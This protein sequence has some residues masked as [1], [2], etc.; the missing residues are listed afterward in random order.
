MA[1]QV[2]AARVIRGL[3]NGWPLVGIASLALAAMTGAVLLVEGTGEA[4]VRL[5]IRATARSSLLI[6]AFA[7]S[8]SSL[9]RLWRSDATKWLLRNRRQ[10]GLSFAVSHFIHLAAIVALARGWPDSFWADGP[11]AIL[12][13]G[14]VGYVFV[15]AM[16]ATSF[17]RSAAWLGRRRW[18]RLHLTGSWVLWSIFAF[19]Y[20]ARVATGQLGFLPLALLVLAVPGLRLAARRRTAGGG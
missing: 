14:G 10:I 13:G 4:G 19:S 16:T 7:F 20:L 3:P 5:L 11:T 2:Q 1:E 6:F 17:D 8:A 18:R 9:H 15:A 12:V